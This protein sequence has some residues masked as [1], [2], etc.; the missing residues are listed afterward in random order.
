MLQLTRKFL[1]P[2]HQ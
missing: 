2:N 1:L